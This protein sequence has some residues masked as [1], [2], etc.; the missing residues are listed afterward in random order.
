MMQNQ[1]GYLN[2]DTTLTMLLEIDGKSNNLL[3]TSSVPAILSI[4]GEPNISC[5]NTD[6]ESCKTSFQKIL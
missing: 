1:R 3:L 4:E 5:Y 2:G 6:C